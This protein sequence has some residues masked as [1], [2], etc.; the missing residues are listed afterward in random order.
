MSKLKKAFSIWQFAW[1]EKRCV[2]IM[3]PVSICFLIKTHS[4]KITAEFGKYKNT[5][6]FYSII[7]IWQEKYMQW[8]EKKQHAMP[9]NIIFSY[10]LDEMSKHSNSIHS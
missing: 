8:M 9:A 5:L 7:V 4:E 1:I 6:I 2:Q 10:L 3:S